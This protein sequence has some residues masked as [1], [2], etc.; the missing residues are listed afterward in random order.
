MDLRIEFW[1]GLSGGN[2]FY[3]FNRDGNRLERDEMLPALALRPLGFALFQ[4]FPVRFFIA[5]RERA[6]SFLS[7]T[8]FRRTNT[9][10][11]KHVERN[12]GLYFAVRLAFSRDVKTLSFHRRTLREDKNGKQGKHFW[13]RRDYSNRVLLC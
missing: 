13:E 11:R 5:K 6:R 12:D 1:T 4:S 3:E 10:K 9:D 2:L 8:I 7:N